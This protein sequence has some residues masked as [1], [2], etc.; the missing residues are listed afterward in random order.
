[1]YNFSCNINVLAQANI[2]NAESGTDLKRTFY[3]KDKVISQIKW[4]DKNKQIYRIKTFYKSGH[5]NEDFV[6]ANGKLNGKSYKFNKKGEKLTTWNFK[7]GRLISRNDHILEF[8]KKNEEKVKAY[9]KKLKELNQAIL[10]N[11]NSVKLHGQRA[12]IRHYLGNYTLALYDYK[13]LEKKMLKIQET[14]KLPE[15]LVGSVYDHLGSIYSYYEMENHAVHYKFKAIIASPK[16]SRLYY[17]IGNYLIKTKNYRLGI[18]FLN[19]AI[20]MVPG[21]SFAYWGLSAAYSD[22]ENYDKAMTCVNIA[23]KNEATLYKR[24]VGNPERDLRTIRGLV[25]HKLG[26]S[27]KGI[28]DLEEALRINP[29][30]SFALRNLG[31]I[32]HDLGEYKTSCKL[33]EKAK[34]LGYEKTHDR[35]D[36]QTYLNYSCNNKSI[37]SLATNTVTKPYVYPNPAEDIIRIKNYNIKNFKYSLYNFESKLMHTGNASNGS[38]NISSLPPGL[39]ILEVE[40]NKLINTFKIVK[41]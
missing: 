8:N 33:L 30:N 16:E 6:F 32:Y 26:E 5:P 37:P 9:H 1:M 41:N 10:E 38:I 29:D 7:N 21:H 20:E 39:Y 17:N 36:I 13:R 24:G 18:T 2:L 35:Y 4:Y 3:F 27:D 31:L 14:N 25:Y 40:A 19:R 12:R 11:P 23:F 15:K 22:L 28:S 34:N